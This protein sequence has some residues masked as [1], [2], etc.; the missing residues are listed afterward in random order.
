MSLMLTLLRLVR[1]RKRLH[2]GSCTSGRCNAMYLGSTSDKS[3]VDEE[4]EHQ[5][6][7]DERQMISSNHKH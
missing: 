4:E 3:L 6:I 5:M 1:R 2:K 7:G